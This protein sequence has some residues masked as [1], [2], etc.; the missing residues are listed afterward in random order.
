MAKMDVRL[1]L[2]VIINLIDNA[3]KYTPA[4]S[5]IEVASQEKRKYGGSVCQ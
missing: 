4:G 2:Q 1:I 5:V 3:L